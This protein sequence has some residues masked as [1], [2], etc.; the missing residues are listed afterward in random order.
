[1]VATITP[2]HNDQT[3]IV[4]AIK[5]V[6]MQGVPVTHYIY[7]DGSF[8]GSRAVVNEFIKEHPEVKIKF[9]ISNKKAGQSFA[10]NLLIKEALKDG[11]KYI[12][13][14]DS[15]DEWTDKEHLDLSIKKLEGTPKFDVVY[16]LP[17]W[18]NEIG[19]PVVPVGIP[20]PRIFIGKHFEHNNFIWISGI[21]TR[22]ECFTNMEFDSA[23]DGIEDWDMWYRLHKRGF[24]FTN[25]RK[26]TF[27]Y[28]VRATG[29]ASK[30]GEKLPLLHKKH[31]FN[32]PK[33]KLH[34]ACG[35]DYK[36]GYVNSDLYPLGT[37]KVDAIFDAKIVP[38]E[39]NTVDEILA[40]HVIEHFHFKEGIEVLKEWCR[41]L[42][43]GGKLVVETPDFLESCKAFIVANPAFRNQLYGH[44]FAFPEMPGQVHKFLFTEEQLRIELGWA[45]FKEVNRIAPFS[46][47]VQPHMINLFLAME[48][49][50]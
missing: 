8:D 25:D 1:M 23:L 17:I 10:R 46:H 15:D 26:V 18:V 48:A 21:V 4:N 29:A 20:V 36:E 2:L 22:A 11:N 16:G 37:A 19:S 30:S 5:S 38:Y 43:P 24:K 47:Y 42:K 28:L 50:K 6:A 49:T 39:D 45:G 12:A 27:K 40:S 3:R 33:L 9:L 34:L 35:E 31:G 13:F 32:L 41:V 14:L 7:D 44:F